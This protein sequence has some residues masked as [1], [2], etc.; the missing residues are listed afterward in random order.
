MAVAWNVGKHPPELPFMLFSLGGALM[1]LAL[2]L[3][4]GRRAATWLLP[5]TLI[6]GDALRAFIF[7]IVAIFL[8]LRFLLGAWQ[9]YSYP[10]VLGIGA[11]LILATAGWIA[12]LRWFRRHA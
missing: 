7:H 4:G 1:V 5:L 3:W 2:C 9:V 10:Q 8:V 11:L 6:G 12:L